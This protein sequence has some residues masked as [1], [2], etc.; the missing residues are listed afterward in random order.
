MFL[1]RANRHNRPAR[2][3]SDRVHYEVVEDLP[4]A[5]RIGAYP[6]GIRNLKS[7]MNG[8]TTREGRCCSNNASQFR[9]CVT[10]LN[11]KTQLARFGESDV[12]QI[13]DH[14]AKQHHLLM[15]RRKCLECRH[16][17]PILKGLQ[18]AAKIG[19]GCS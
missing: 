7:Q 4:E 13:V 14:P 18:L 11:F 10:I 1:S 8:T 15:A 6:K 2:S 19:Q 5:S 17:Q 16:R 3:M 9:R 12:T